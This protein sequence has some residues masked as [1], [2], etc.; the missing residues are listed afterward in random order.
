M[1]RAAERL[2]WRG[3]RA[4]RAMPSFVKSLL[5]WTLPAVAP[6]LPMCVPGKVP[7]VVV[8]GRFVTPGVF[9]FN[10]LE[11]TEYCVGETLLWLRLVGFSRI[12]SGTVF[13]RPTFSR[14]WLEKIATNRGGV[15]W[16]FV[17]ISLAADLPS[18]CSG[19]LRARCGPL[20]AR[21]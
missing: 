2:C 15:L 6:L 19:T 21:F 8:V 9:F 3:V 20:V 18:F 1:T 17:K 10:K 14:K 12:P 16:R 4:R 11:N 5:V 7:G 13:L